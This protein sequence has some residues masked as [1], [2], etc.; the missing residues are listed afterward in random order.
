MGGLMQP[1]PFWPDDRRWFAAT[2]VD[3]WS[4]YIAGDQ[5]FITQLASD[6]PTHSE[7]VTLD[8]QLEAAV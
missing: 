7:L 2:D 1:Q 6:V 5:S 4:L 8:L 3:F